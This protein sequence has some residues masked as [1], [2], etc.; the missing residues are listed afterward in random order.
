MK[1]DHEAYKE[2]PWL[3]YHE[4][5]FVGAVDNIL[6][7]HDIRIQIKRKWL[8]GYSFRRGKVTVNISNK[9]EIDH[10]PDNLFPKIADQLEQLLLLKN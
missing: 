3:L 6:T 5:T 2:T 8:D 7:F 9:G 1:I 4:D 10:C